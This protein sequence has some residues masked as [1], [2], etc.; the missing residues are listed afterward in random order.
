MKSNPN[1]QWTQFVNT[2]APVAVAVCGP[3]TTTPNTVSLGEQPSGTEVVV[4]MYVQNPGEPAKPTKHS[5]VAGEATVT[6][7][8]DIQW[9]VD[10]EDGGGPP[11]DVLVTIDNG[12]PAVYGTN[13]GAPD[14][15]G[16]AA[17]PV[18]TATGNFEHSLPVVSY[19]SQV[20]G[21][22]LVAT[23]NSRD[24]YGS[25]LGFGVGWVTDLDVALVTEPNGS[26]TY[27]DPKGRRVALVS[28]G[29][30]AWYA[31]E[32][33]VGSVV[34]LSSP[35]RFAI[36]F[37]AGERWEFDSTGRLVTKCQGQPGWSG[38]A[39]SCSGSSST[40]G[41][42]VTV[43]WT[44]AHPSGVSSSNGMSQSFT[45]DSTGSRVMTIVAHDDTNAAHDRQVDVGY[46]TAAPAATLALLT[47]PRFS[48]DTGYPISTFGRDTSTSSRFRL[49][50][51]A[52]TA[53]DGS[54]YP[55]PTQSVRVVDN[56]YDA[57]GRVTAQTQSSGDLTSFT[58]N[59]TA[60]LVTVKWFP[61]ACD[62]ACQAT[63]SVSSGCE[64]ATYTHDANQRLTTL[65]DTTG[66]STGRTWTQPGTAGFPQTAA[67]T[68]AQDRTGGKQGFTYDNAGRMV[69]RVTGDP[70]T[71]YIPSDSTSDSCHRD[72]TTGVYPAAGS[73]GCTG[74]AYT[75]ES[76]AYD[77]SGRIT[78]QTNGAGEL[79][80]YVYN[81][82]NASA[83]PDQIRTGDNTDDSTNAPTVV[84]TLEHAGNLITSRSSGGSKTC[85]LYD[86]AGRVTVETPN[87][88]G[89]CPTA[90]SSTST[91]STYGALGQLE[92]VARPKPDASG[93]ATWS[94]AYY[95]WGPLKSQTDPTSNNHPTTYTYYPTGETKTVTD[96][97]GKTTTTAIARYITDTGTC[98]SGVATPCRTVV[99]CGPGVTPCDTTAVTNVANDAT[100]DVY[101]TA[102]HRVRSIAAGGAETTYTYGPLGRLTQV[103]APPTATTTSGDRIVTKYSYDNNGR[104]TGVQAGSND[105][106]AGVVESTQF[107]RRG[108]VTTRTSRQADAGT[109][110]TTSYTYDAA[111][112]VATTT[113][114]TGGD[115]KTTTTTYF[116]T[117]AVKE[118]NLNRPDYWPGTIPESH[119]FRYD[120]AGR[121]VATT[122]RTAYNVY[123]STETATTAKTTY[124]AATGKP[125][126]TYTPLPGSPDCT[127]TGATCAVTATQYYG[128]GSIQATKTPDQF[129]AHPAFDSDLFQTSYA[130]D[131]AGRTTTVTTPN[132]AYTT[133]GSPPS[134][135][136]TT[137][138]STTC[139]N[140]RGD[141]VAVIDP[142]GAT[143]YGYTDGGRLADVWDPTGTTGSTCATVAAVSGNKGHVRYVYDG[144]GNRLER[145]AWDD[146]TPTRNELVEHW[147]YTLDNRPSTYTDAAGRPT[148][149]S[150][151]LAN[152]RLTSKA[153]QTGDVSDIDGAGNAASSKRV[154]TEDYLPNGAVGTV[155]ARAYDAS[156]S[157]TGTIVVGY[158]YDTVG[159]RKQ[160]IANPGASQTV[161]TF[162]YNTRDQVLSLAYQGGGTASY[163]WNLGGQQTTATYPNGAGWRFLYD[164]AGRVQ[165]VDLLAFF[166]WNPVATY[167]YS[168]G[169]NPTYAA[170][171]STSAGTRSYT[172]DPSTGATTRMLQTVAGTTTNFDMAFDNDGRLALD[173]R[174]TH[175][176]PCAPATDKPVT[177]GYD[178]A[179]QLTTS[180]VA[181]PA[182][183]DV[184]AWGYSYGNRGN[185][186]TSTVTTRT[187]GAD[188]V[189][190]T[191]YTTDGTGQLTAAASSTGGDNATWRYDKAGRRLATVRTSGENQTLTYDPLG[192]LAG[193][194]VTG[195]QWNGT[196]ARSYD[197]LGS[198][199]TITRTNGT[200]D[201]LALSWDHSGRD[202]VSQINLSTLN[203]VGDQ[204]SYGIDR[205]TMQDS[206]GYWFNYD[207]LGS[208]IYKPVTA[209]TPNGG[210]TP[211]STN[212]AWNYFGYRAELT[213]GNLIHLRNRDYDPTTGTF[214]TRDPLDGV[215]GTPAESNPY[216]YTGNDPLN[217]ADPS[218][219]RPGD[220]TLIHAVG[221]GVT[222]FPAVDDGIFLADNDPRCAPYKARYPN[223]HI[224]TDGVTCFTGPDA[225]TTVESETDRAFVPFVG[226]YPV[227]SD[228]SYVRLPDFAKRI[229]GVDD[230]PTSCTFFFSEKFTTFLWDLIS[231]KHKT[232]DDI[233]Q[234]I[235]C[236]STSGAQFK[237]RLQE[238]GRYVGTTDCVQFLSSVVGESFEQN[239]LWAREHNDGCLTIRYELE[240]QVSMGSPPDPVI[241]GYYP[242]I[243]WSY[244]RF[245]EDLRCHP[246]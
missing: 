223:S 66:Q 231:G 14:Y 146:A 60:H 34:R 42:V 243:W 20:Y 73:A 43:S 177:Y 44:G 84:T 86:T 145:H 178:A 57:D 172:V 229:P 136:P 92:S 41:Q 123:N 40:A 18:N 70:S 53:A 239:I 114:G 52:V 107:D 213:L 151:T 68:S 180:T 185:R 156:N 88:V 69:Q 55:D 214:L 233:V 140:D 21:M 162:T 132:P 148:A 63:C 4:T 197:A 51:F 46:N 89:A 208:T 58:W 2:T 160:V 100:V 15:V 78:S 82:G 29:A 202:P 83:V 120:N 138:G 217:R 173:C 135:T 35:T 226:R 154:T 9:V 129:A 246:S 218:G 110:V 241:N 62:G 50:T 244:A 28:S 225:Q 95:G 17:D 242:R 164:P 221:F 91:D 108:R 204:Y 76:F 16:H 211:A 19:P 147:T 183:G 23:Y 96:P 79:T 174:Y 71:G 198:L 237:A 232:K 165:E 38:T 115:A 191:A 81:A 134:G 150:Y 181:N 143:V 124:D 25:S 238:F 169:G 186:A 94:Y 170:L 121:T 200:T 195:G 77:S 13:G 152:G 7:I 8:S 102:D 175:T 45:Y 72:Q 125:D 166:T 24:P 133:V 99:R 163:G 220:A 61:S 222:P 193:R 128:T 10:F 75:I 205:V 179:S 168:A 176:A 188:S 65:A 236:G 228:C 141:R 207:D 137:V 106:A 209:Y 116:K 235:F 130:Y 5:N 122:D 171:A 245:P 56:T 182:V 67:A 26:L 98:G 119:R 36:Q 109:V 206:V 126:K 59:D 144:R 112:R 54:G 22:G 105:S 48:T 159:R 187:S 6:K 142:G 219:Q 227:R 203:G 31:P 33:I 184:K 210:P 234:S 49:A 131:A 190:T 201:T 161:N 189:A 80:T 30:D 3:C 64:T 212:T 37:S 118:T 216:H 90:S 240:F 157:V 230:V 196:E 74:K 27:R 97:L 215:T 199:T 32:G 117:G 47:A 153:T 11:T 139:Y 104:V 87:V 101:D 39:D 85:M 93:K 113:V 103:T 149:T 167:T 111:D 158:S 1:A 12:D 194:T 155:T 192:R 224:Y 127:A